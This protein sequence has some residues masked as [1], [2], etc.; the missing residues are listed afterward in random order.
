MQKSLDLGDIFIVAF[1]AV[2]FI[3]GVYMVFKFMRS[4][5]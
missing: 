5:S 1:V 3:A 4:K 2:V